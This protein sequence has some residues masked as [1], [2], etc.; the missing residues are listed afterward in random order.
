M[1]IASLALDLDLEGNDLDGNYHEGKF[2]SR[3]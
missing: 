3:A 1:L 2:Q